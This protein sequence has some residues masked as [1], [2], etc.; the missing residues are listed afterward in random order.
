MAPSQI[1][2]HTYWMKIK[3]K[4][5]LTKKMT[6][7][8]F[9]S[10]L[11]TSMASASMNRGTSGKDSTAMISV[12][13]G[14]SMPSYGTALATNPAGLTEVPGTNLVLQDGTDSKFSN[15]LFTAGL[16]YGD[17]NV[18]LEGGLNY[19][20]KGDAIGGFFGLGFGIPSI[21]TSIGFTGYL[22]LSPSSGISLNAGL[23]IMPADSVSLGIT[24]VGLN[25]SGGVDEIGA[26][27]GFH[28]N[29]NVGIALDSTFSNDFK[30]RTFEPGVKVGTEKASLMLAYGFGSNSVQLSNDEISLGAAFR[31][32][33][34]ILWEIYYNKFSTYYTGFTIQI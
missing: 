23:L 7:S 4:R 9:L 33:D 25:H 15:S 21:R 11:T 19:S 8:L 22:G 6:Y 1:F 12:A 14:I 2:V 29:P 32:K 34:R 26:G 20:N 31:F 13:G 24:L 28:I 5:S 10:I 30:F 17:G 3:I 27:V 18:G 16:A